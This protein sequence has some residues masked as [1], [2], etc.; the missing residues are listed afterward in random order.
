[1]PC[2]AE[3]LKNGATVR[4]SQYATIYVKIDR[5]CIQTVYGQGY[6]GVYM[7]RCNN[8]LEG[9][10][11]FELKVKG[12]SYFYFILIMNISI[13]PIFQHIDTPGYSQSD[14]YNDCDDPSRW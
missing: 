6:A 13:I 3:L 9:K 10:I 1:M 4:S 11:S 5:I 12:K 7:L 2:T 14:D 8:G